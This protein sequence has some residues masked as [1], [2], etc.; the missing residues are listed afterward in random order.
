MKRSEIVIAL[1]NVA[2]KGKYEVTPQGAKI[3]NDV[4]AQAAA[5]INELEAEENAAVEETP[6]E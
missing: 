1:A 4:F 6:S 5:L 3:M 2:S